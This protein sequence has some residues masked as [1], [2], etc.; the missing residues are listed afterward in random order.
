M[1]I[2]PIHPEPNLFNID[3]WHGWVVKG[4][5]LVWFWGLR[6]KVLV[7]NLGTLWLR[8]LDCL[9]SLDWPEVAIIDVKRCPIFNDDKRKSHG[10]TPC[11][12]EVLKADLGV[13]DLVLLKIN[14][15]GRFF[16]PLVD[17]DGVEL[18]HYIDLSEDAPKVLMVLQSNP[19]KMSAYELSEVTKEVSI[20]YLQNSAGWAL[21]DQGMANKNLRKNQMPIGKLDG[22]ERLRFFYLL[23]D[24]VWKISLGNFGYGVLI[25]LYKVCILF[26][27]FYLFLYLLCGI[28]R[29]I[30][31]QRIVCGLVEWFIF[32]LVILWF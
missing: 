28:F 2:I 1:D 11:H 24:D 14:L 31:L 15:L 29:G 5:V 26:H 3:E 18:E 8:R 12:L 22:A 10:A 17:P 23:V 25:E 30:W 6:V 7:V 20:H 13:A 9:I 4:K 16:Q 21:D 19:I 32:L 27:Q